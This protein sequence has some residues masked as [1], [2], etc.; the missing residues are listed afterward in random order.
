MKKF[1][2][3]LAVWF[4][5]AGVALFALVWIRG[6]LRKD[7]ISLPIGAGGV[8]VISHPHHLM[9]QRANVLVPR[10]PASW[11]LWD[12]PIPARMA[13]LE[14]RFVH[15]PNAWCLWLPHWLPMLL[16][17][18]LPIW[19]LVRRSRQRGRVARGLCVNCGYDLRASGERCPECGAVI[20]T[21]D[22]IG[23]GAIA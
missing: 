10:L 11:K 6:L 19:Q 23:S 3:N 20:A 12:S 9:I 14:V 17:S 8:I 5:V 7:Q 15:D 13:Y 21:S 22:G 1:F 2:R 18:G 16:L 4:C